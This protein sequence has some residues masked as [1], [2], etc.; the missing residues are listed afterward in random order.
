[1][2]SDEIRKH[3]EKQLSNLKT[4]MLGETKEDAM[5]LVNALNASMSVFLLGEIAAQLAE[6]NERQEANQGNSV[7]HRLHVQV[8][9]L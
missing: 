7:N 6:L 9:Q 5:H 8:H 2:T 4:T 3:T 1:M